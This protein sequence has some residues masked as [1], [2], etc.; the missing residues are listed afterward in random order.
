MKKY[1]S[2]LLTLVLLLSFSSSVFAQEENRA[3]AQALASALVQ[4][5]D[6]QS[7]WSSYSDEEKLAVKEFASQATSLLEQYAA[8]GTR[9]K[10][11]SAK[12]ANLSNDEALAVAV[13]LV[14]VDISEKD[15]TLLAAGTYTYGRE[16]EGT[17]LVGGVLWRLTHSIE[18]N[19]KSNGY[20]DR[21]NRTITPYVAT[22]AL[23]WSYNGTTTDQQEGGVGWN[24][25]QSD[26]VGNFRFDILEQPVQNRYPRI[27]LQ[28]WADGTVYYQH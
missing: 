25:Y 21:A 24:Y 27:W 7:L 16:V 26:V 22:W 8:E 3:D 13:S 5:Q 20:L 28:G 18:W 17:N 9:S 10:T 1:L 12:T 11:L 2:V 19:V 23:G 14:Q 15:I 6:A 4:S